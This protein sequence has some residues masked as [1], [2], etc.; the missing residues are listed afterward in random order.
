MPN[1]AFHDI[2]SEIRRFAETVKD[3]TSLQEFCVQIMAGWL[4]YDNWVGFDMLDSS[5]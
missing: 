2:V 1:P 4:S 3:L 5:D